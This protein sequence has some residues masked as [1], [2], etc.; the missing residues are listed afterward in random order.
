MGGLC[1]GARW[2]TLLGPT[3]IGALGGADQILRTAH[4][5]IEVTPFSNLLMIRAGDAEIGDVNRAQNLP[6]LRAL[7]A[8][9]KPITL[10]GDQSLQNVLDS[11]A[12]DWERRFLS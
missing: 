12:E 3:Q 1:R 11:R 4:A 8:Q 7:A 5:G 6:L 10:F 9:L 2:I